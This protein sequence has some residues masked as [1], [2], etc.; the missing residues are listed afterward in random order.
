M[1]TRL[2]VIFWRRWGNNPWPPVETLGSF[3]S[4][5]CNV[6]CVR[7]DI[8]DAEIERDDLQSCP[9]YSG[10]V[11]WGSQA[12]NLRNVACACYVRTQQF[13][14]LYFKRSLSSWGQNSNTGI[15]DVIVFRVDSRWSRRSC[16]VSPS[17]IICSDAAD[18]P[19]VPVKPLVF[20]KV[21][22]CCGTDPTTLISSPS[23][24]TGDDPCFWCSSKTKG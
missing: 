13:S 19:E 14:F 20:T 16:S 12:R 8:N 17:I 4:W 2:Q 5:W 11:L 22:R 3:S 6:Q 10:F 23:S 7:H 1:E 21:Y 9:E 18:V 24:E 15:A